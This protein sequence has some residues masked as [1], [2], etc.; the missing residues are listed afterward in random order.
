MKLIRK[1]TE[2]EIKLIELLINKSLLKFLNWKDKMMVKEMNDGGMGSL[3]LFSN[4]FYEKKKRFA[5]QISE[6]EFL[7]VDGVLVSVALYI[8]EVDNELCE[9]DI[10]KVDF[11]PLIKIN[12]EY[13]DE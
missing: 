1:P 7:D 8:N 4:G 3:T 9:L 12:V 11:N 6:Y 2:L 5:K 10:W 13:S